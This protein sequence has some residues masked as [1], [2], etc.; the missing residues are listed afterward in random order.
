MNQPTT[1]RPESTNASAH[2]PA[3][4]APPAFN[5]RDAERAAKALESTGLYKVMRKMPGMPLGQCP[6]IRQGLST[7]I[8]LDTETTGLSAAEDKVIE[9]GMI[10]RR[11]DNKTGRFVGEA[12]EACWLEHPGFPLEPHTVALTGITDEMLIGQ[13]FDEEAI[14][15]FMSDA[16][17]VIAHSAWHDRPFFE[18]RFPLMNDFDW[19]CSLKQVDWQTSGMG[20]SKLEF[21]SFKLGYFY[22][23]HRALPDCHALGH[24]LDETILP[25]GKTVLAHL[26]DVAFKPDFRIHATGA[27]FDSKDALKARGYHWDG[28]QKVWH[29]TVSEDELDAELEWL[30]ANAYN[31]RSARV[32]MSVLSSRARFSVAPPVGS[33]RE[34]VRSI[35][36]QGDGPV[37]TTGRAARFSGTAR[38]Y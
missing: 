37:A 27:P 19:A 34:D 33:V 32:R 31:G 15:R 13:R 18:A 30:H 35:G 9:V 26:L 12:E 1:A 20:S 4:S 29:T 17:L 6:E 14:K 23:A 21:L 3:T 5:A 2:A 8:V 10:K 7:I 11:V 28:E 22:E 38:R 16:D 24:V 25:S 36:P